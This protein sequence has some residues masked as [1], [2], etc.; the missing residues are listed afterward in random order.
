MLDTQTVVEVEDLEFQ[1]E[2]LGH[3]LVTVERVDDEPQSDD[4]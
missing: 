2:S 1:G 4:H 3:W